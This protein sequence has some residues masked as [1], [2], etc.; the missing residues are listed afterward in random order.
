M[1]KRLLII[2]LLSMLVFL[3]TCWTAKYAIYAGGW[4]ES[5]AYFVLTYILLEKYGKPQTFNVP[6]ITIV[7]F[8]R[9]FLE[10]PIRILDFWNSLFSMFIPMIVIASIILAAT[11]YREKRYSVLI[12]SVVI[13][14][15]LNTIGHHFWYDL[16][17]NKI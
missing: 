13:L 3:L 10:L 14:I 11:Y 12:L 15:L 5:V 6:I 1:K 16:V 8:G 4:T 17:T 2:F 9:I 7:M